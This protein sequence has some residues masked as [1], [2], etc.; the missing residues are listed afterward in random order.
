MIYR[1][2]WAG[3]KISLLRWEVKVISRLDVEK[4]DTMEG[5]NLMRSKKV[6]DIMKITEG[7][8]PL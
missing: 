5:E 3:P 1:G 8:F 2:K 6:G 4:I 7:I